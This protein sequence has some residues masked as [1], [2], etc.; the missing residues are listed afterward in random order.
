MKQ[1]S[2][3]GKIIDSKS[4]HAIDRWGKKMPEN[5]GKEI[6]SMIWAYTKVTGRLENKS[7]I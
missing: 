2:Y 5:A 1:A 4:I 7:H 6:P 3:V